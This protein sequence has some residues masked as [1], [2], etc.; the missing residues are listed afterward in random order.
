MP[1]IKDSVGDG[2]TNH[3]HDVALV[4]AMLRIVKDAKGAPYLPGNYDGVYGNSTKGAITRFQAEHKLVPP[5]GGAEKLGQIAA[6]GPTNQALSGLLPA[7]YADLR[8]LT[9]SKTVYLPSDAADAKTSR[10]EISTYQEF[11]TAF[12]GKVGDLVNEMFDVHKVA[13]WVQASKGWRRTFAE[14]ADPG[15]NT[16][17]GPGESNHN[18]GRAA[19]L[20]FKSFRWLRGDG[21]PHQDDDWLNSLHK[22]KA[23]EAAA[24]WDARDVF[25][26]K[27]GLFRLGFERIHLQSYDQKLIS[28]QSSLAKLLNT[29]GTMGWKAGYQ[30]DLGSGGKYW[31]KVGTAKDI[32]GLSSTL[33]KADI[34]KAMTAAAGKAVKE[35]DIKAQKLIDTKKA[36]KGDFEAAEK[37]WIKWT[38]VP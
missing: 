20:G 35:A 13:L 31:A 7:A 10:K 18:F 22:V 8:I 34:A 27:L 6:A 11:E 15:L 28:S 2:G 1:D 16:K 5:T 25:A 23:A 12:R 37:N 4:Q 24:L 33:T 30:C 36:L 38:G 29:V 14:Q 19:D 21:T 32:W 9:N 26:K 17:A 3:T